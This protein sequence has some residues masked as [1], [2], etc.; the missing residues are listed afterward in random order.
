[1]S[2][3]INNRF[4]AIASQ[5][6]VS[7]DTK[8][9]PAKLVRGQVCEAVPVVVRRNMQNTKKRSAQTLNQATTTVVCDLFELVA[10]FLQS[11]PGCFNPR[12]LPEPSWGCACVLVEHARKVTRTHAGLGSKLFYRQGRGPSVS[13]AGATTL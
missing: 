6:W 8:P 9:S 5:Q 4:I 11:A 2:K 13:G 12:V 10:R 7:R 1:M 3:L